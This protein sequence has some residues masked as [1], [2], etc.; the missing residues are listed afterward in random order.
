MDRCC[1]KITLYHC[2][3]P[4]WPVKIGFCEYCRDWEQE[5]FVGR[6][7][8]TDNTRP[9]AAPM[10][11]RH[12]WHVTLPVKISR[13]LSDL[14]RWNFEDYVYFLLCFMLLQ[15]TLADP[16]LSSLSRISHF[17]WNIFRKL[18]SVEQLNYTSR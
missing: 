12:L 10:W 7:Y 2:R 15:R 14:G 17:Q 11:W 16:A 6:Y 4:L 1:L 18:L 3:L 8:L 13:K 9:C 5:I